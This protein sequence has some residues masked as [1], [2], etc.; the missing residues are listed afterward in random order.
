MIT[1]AAVDGMNTAATSQ[2]DNLLEAP[3]DENSGSQPVG[4]DR[5]TG[6]TTLETNNLTATEPNINEP[7]GDLEESDGLIVGSG[8]AGP[9]GN[10][11]G[12][13]ASDLSAITHA[14]GLAI[15]DEYF[16]RPVAESGLLNGPLEL[17]PPTPPAPVA[18]SAS[19][20][21]VQVPSA[22]L[23]AEVLTESEG[24]H[25]ER[26]IESV[27]ATAS[28]SRSGS[29]GSVFS[30]TNS[31]RCQL[32]ETNATEVDA[33]DMATYPSFTKRAVLDEGP[34]LLGHV[35]EALRK[36]EDDRRAPT[37]RILGVLDGSIPRVTTKP[38]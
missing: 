17:E 14:D 10:G 7:V 25:P 18:L 29:P 20:D 19:P 23:S 28:V 15:L 21:I 1:D 3:A 13:R 32:C 30:S 24:A 34:Q 31:T 33:P 16:P 27:E 37:A 8:L 36:T 5:T 9:V 11:G 22:N 26:V 4:D 2:H 6:P 35:L 38:L 12:I